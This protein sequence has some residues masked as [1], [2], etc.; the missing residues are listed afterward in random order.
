MPLKNSST[1]EPIDFVIR[2]TQDGVTY[3]TQKFYSEWGTPHTTLDVTPSPCHNGNGK[4]APSAYSYT[5]TKSVYPKG[6]YVQEYV[7]AGSV[8]QII[9]E[10]KFGTT[11][12]AFG[13]PRPPSQRDALEYRALSKLYDQIRSS[14]V[15]LNT[16]IGEGRE[17]LKMI[18]D[19]AVSA[20]KAKKGLKKLG[21]DLTLNPLQT[22]G[23]LYL[24]WSVG[25]SPLLNDCENIRK[26]MAN[27]DNDTVRCRPITA[28]ASSYDVKSGASWDITLSERL[29]YG[30]SW[31]LSNLHLF[32]NWR[33]G[34]TARPTLLWELTT[35]S[36]VVD[37]FVS[38]G[39]YLELLE[40]SLLNNGVEFVNGYRTFTTKTVE[41]LHYDLAGPPATDM[42]PVLK[43]YKIDAVEVTV[44][45][46]REIITSFPRPPLPV[47]KIPRA[48]GPLLNVAAL[49]SQILT[50]R[51]K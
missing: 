50:R 25:L 42:T 29:Q 13:F 5:S 19:I 17:T 10:G 2:Y 23:G 37:Y 40:A 4:T 20:V 21:K 39:K 14:E 7:Y 24:G 35:L 49:L 18:R 30:L 51:I 48:A 26:H 41:D 9:Q 15:S 34:L 11:Y 6:I 27:E 43:K 45:K 33:L 1:R 31:R 8:Y 44:A 46:R 3:D 16:S 28:R 32:E 38:I 22:V 47:V 36:F 12:G